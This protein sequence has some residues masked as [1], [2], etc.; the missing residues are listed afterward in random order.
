MLHNRPQFLAA[1]CF[2][3]ILMAGQTM[4]AGTVDDITVEPRWSKMWLS[5]RLTANWINLS[6]SG[7]SS[8]EPP[9]GDVSI[10]LPAGIRCLW[11]YGG[12]NFRQTPLKEGV[13]HLILP[14]VALNGSQAV[15]LYLAT[16]LKPGTTA[17]GRSWAESQGKKSAVSEFAIEV[18]D[19]PVARQ[20]ITERKRCFQDRSQE[21]RDFLGG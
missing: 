13:T 18:V 11:V 10:I 14:S 7:A 5:P 16:D 17:T 1:Q 19:V 8:K 21:F 4:L 15:Y 3:L 9:V 20:P 2:V 12:L 6:Y